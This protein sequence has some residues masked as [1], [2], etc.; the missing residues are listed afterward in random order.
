ML[1]L[2]KTQLHNSPLFTV[3]I[4]PTFYISEM[5][6]SNARLVLIYI[7]ST[8]NSLDVMSLWGHRTCGVH[9]V[10]TSVGAMLESVSFNGI[11]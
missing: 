11:R 3:N 10:G 1:F 2:K 5:Y 8:T 9:V 6:G 7:Q 4:G